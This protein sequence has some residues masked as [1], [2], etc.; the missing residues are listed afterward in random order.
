MAQLAVLTLQ[1]YK[2]AL[3]QEEQRT[4]AFLRMQQEAQAKEAE[5]EADKKRIWE[6]E[7]ASKKF[8]VC[9]CLPLLQS[10]AVGQS[11]PVVSG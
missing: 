1:M 2:A 7:I 6:E 10:D 5:Q 9:C 4:P 8:W 11:C 3:Q